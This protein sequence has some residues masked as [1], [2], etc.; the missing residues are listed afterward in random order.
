M[1]YGLRLFDDAIAAIMTQFNVAYKML[2]LPFV[3]LIL[4]AAYQVIPGRYSLGYR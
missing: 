4:S 3:R 2:P 1:F